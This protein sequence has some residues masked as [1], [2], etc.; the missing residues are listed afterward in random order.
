MPELRTFFKPDIPILL[1]G[2]K[3]DL[4]SVSGQTRCLISRT[5]GETLAA[6][7]GAWGYIEC[8]AYYLESSLVVFEAAARAGL[9][10]GHVR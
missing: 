1:V 5:A 4:R 9:M 7:I 8:S 2:C 3:A 10:A 6:E